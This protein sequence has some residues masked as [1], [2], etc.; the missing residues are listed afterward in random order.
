[1]DYSMCYGV[2]G[3]AT[4]TGNFGSAFLNDESDGHGWGHLSV[5]ML[6]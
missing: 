4:L 6:Y 5:R 3:T 2:K 1:M